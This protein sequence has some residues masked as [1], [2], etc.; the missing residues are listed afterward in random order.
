MQKI[1]RPPEVAVVRQL[2]F[3]EVM[4]VIGTFRVYVFI[5]DKMLPV[6]LWNKCVAGMEAAQLNTGESAF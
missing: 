2:N 1:L 5:N 3:V 4:E 6:F